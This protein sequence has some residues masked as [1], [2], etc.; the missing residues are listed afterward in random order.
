MSFSTKAAH[1]LMTPK[2][3]SLLY[4]TYIHEIQR[5]IPFVDVVVCECEENITFSY[6][7]HD[8]KYKRYLVN[9]KW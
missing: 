7:K 9:G 1:S 6:L 5:G 8:K 2:T 3:F 4:L